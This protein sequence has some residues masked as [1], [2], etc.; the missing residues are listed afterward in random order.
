MFFFIRIYPHKPAD[1][2]LVAILQF[3]G[4][5][6]CEQS[7]PKRIVVALRQEIELTFLPVVL[8]IARTRSP[9]P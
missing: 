9:N 4:T 3:I 6:F 1:R 5:S 8:T 7:R 2:H